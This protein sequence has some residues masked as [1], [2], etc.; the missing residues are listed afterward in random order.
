MGYLNY[1]SQRYFKRINFFLFRG[2]RYPPHGYDL[3]NTMYP[4]QRLSYMYLES[5]K[6]L[7]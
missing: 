7:K 1:R 5:R 6:K 4:C 3:I 2:Y